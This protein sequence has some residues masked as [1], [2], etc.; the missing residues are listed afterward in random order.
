MGQQ[1]S[2]ELHDRNLKDC[3][4]DVGDLVL[5]YNPKVGEEEIP[6]LHRDWSGP[7]VVVTKVS[8]QTYRI[9][10]VGS[11]KQK[12]RKVVHYSR[13]RLYR[14]GTEAGRRRG[15]EGPAQPPRPGRAHVGQPVVRPAG[16]PVGLPTTTAAAPVAAP[17]VVP[18]VVPTTVSAAAPLGE[19]GKQPFT[20]KVEDHEDLSDRGVVK[21][22]VVSDEEA[23][24]V[25]GGFNHHLNE[26]LAQHV[27]DLE[28]VAAV[29]REKEAAAAEEVADREETASEA[30][31]PMVQEELWSDEVEMGDQ[32]SG[33][34]IPMEEYET[35]VGED[36]SDEDAG[37]RRSGRARKAPDRYGEWTVVRRM[38]K[39][40]GR[41]V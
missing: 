14:K 36:G 11:G 3:Q 17:I 34:K 37:V 21:V 30:M 23:D 15:D 7:Y 26:A 8:E 29:S 38:R 40:M 16:A 28:R 9:K 41:K 35:D 32:E 39:G 10:K 4:L 5:W 1:K 20:I 2:K 22:E 25:L 12:D 27:R 6:K 18:E 24:S 31:A 19:P 33:D 13:L